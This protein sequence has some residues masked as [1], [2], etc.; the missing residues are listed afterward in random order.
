MYLHKIMGLFCLIFTF[1]ILTSINIYACEFENEVLIKFKQ[2]VVS[3]PASEPSATLDQITFSSE[4]VNSLLSTY[5]T[6]PIEK[7]FEDTDPEQILIENPAGLITTK[8]TKYGWY[9]ITVQD[10][11]EA[12]NIVESF[13]NS[14]DVIHV[15]QNS[16]I[17]FQS[18]TVDD[19]RFGE[20]WA[21]ENTGQFAGVPGKDIK[22][23]GPGKYLPELLMQ[24]WLWSMVE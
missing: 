14:N 6:L 11:N 4:S 7:L 1:L 24:L 15:Y 22:A 5:T 13:S 2:G 21:L 19:P 23:K 9:K 12:E 10:A 20:Q 8:P 17:S 16:C 3:W 18:V